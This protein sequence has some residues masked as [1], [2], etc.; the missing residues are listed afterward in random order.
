MARR[1]NIWSDHP[2]LHRRDYPGFEAGRCDDVTTIPLMLGMPRPR[3]DSPSGA[4]AL[5]AEASGP[6]VDTFGRVHRDLRISLTD[7][8]SLR[9]T[10]CMPEQGNEW[11]ARSSILTARRDRA[12][13]DASPRPPASRRSASPAASRCCAPTSSTSSAASPRSRARTARPVELAMTTNGIRLPELPA[14]ADRRRPRAASTSRSTPSAATASATSPA[15]TGSTTCSRESRRPRHP[16]SVPSSST[17]SRCATSTTTSSSTS[18]QF[19]L[20]HDARAALHR[21]DAA[22]CRPHVGPLAHGDARRD[23]RHALDALDASTPVPGRGGAPG[24]ALDARRRPAHGRR[25][26]VGHG[27]VL[28]RLR[29]AAAH[30]RRPAAQLP[31]LDDRV[32]PAADPARGRR[33]R[34]CGIDGMLRS[35][36]RGKLPGHAI[37]DPGFLQPARG[38]NAIGG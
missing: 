21:A 25:H 17:P 4:D 23:P 19:A 18:S 11:L 8:C 32:R 37:N 24:R 31:L 35:C 3:A 38:M 20:D 15:A 2:W 27:A 6:L 34:R 13:R 12:D 9:C 10:Y 5:G 1:R 36:V 22:R 7:R 29:S 33:R 16:L 30:R 26:R 28:R 14:R